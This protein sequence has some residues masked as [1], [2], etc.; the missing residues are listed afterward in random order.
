[1][2]DRVLR[3]W[4]AVLTGHADVN[5]CVITVENLQKT[6]YLQSL[7]IKPMKAIGNAL[8]LCSGN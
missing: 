8:N 4:A 5:E 7:K 3:S 2:C 1:M 6:G